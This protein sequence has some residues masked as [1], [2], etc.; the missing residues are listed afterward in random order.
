MN[1]KIIEEL[2]PSKAALLHIEFGRNA[3]DFAS[4]SFKFVFLCENCYTVLHIFLKCVPNGSVDNRACLIQ[5]MLGKPLS[6]PMM[7]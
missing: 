3:R 2:I 7:S 1:N 4:D 5:I 6:E